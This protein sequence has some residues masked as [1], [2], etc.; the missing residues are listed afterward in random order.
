MKI[1]DLGIWVLWLG[2]YSELWLES[3]EFKGF[4]ELK[5]ISTKKKQRRKGVKA[6]KVLVI[7]TLGRRE[8]RGVSAN[9]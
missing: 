4:G 7:G 2:C 6:D 5:K 1:E 3:N 8:F 9:F